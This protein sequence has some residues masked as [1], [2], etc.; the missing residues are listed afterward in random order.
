MVARGLSRAKWSWVT[1]R[2]A[3]SPGSGVGEHHG[4]GAGLGGVSMDLSSGGGAR[5][6]CR[7]DWLLVGLAV[8]EH[9]VDDVDAAAGE[10]DQYGVVSLAL[11][12]FAVV[13]GAAGRVGE[14]GESRQEQRGLQRVVARWERV[15][16]LIE[17]PE[18]RV[19]GAR[20]A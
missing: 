5:S 4:D 19:T 8:G 9:G 18:R 3:E 7:R 15:S 1:R 20:P 2:L 10:A 13:V 17:D 11:S 12:A 14:A 6:G 16:P